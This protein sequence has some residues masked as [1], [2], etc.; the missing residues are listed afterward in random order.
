[1]GFI[2]IIEMD[3]SGVTVTPFD[4]MDIVLYAEVL[5]AVTSRSFTIEDLLGE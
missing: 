5:T 2:E 4:E 3:E 1:M